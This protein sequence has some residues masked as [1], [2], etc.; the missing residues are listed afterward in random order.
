M[1]RDCTEHPLWFAIDEQSHV[2]GIQYNTMTKTTKVASVGLKPARNNNKQSK[3]SKNANKSKPKQAYVPAWGMCL[4]RPWKFMPAHIPDNNTT[5]SGLCTSRQ[6]I[7]GTVQN[8]D[9]APSTTHSFGLVLPPYPYYTQFTSVGTAGATFGQICD[10]T[11][12]GS[13]YTT[14]SGN[15]TFP[16]AIPNSVA[17]LG[18]TSTLSE[19]SRIRCVGLSVKVIYEGTD[20]QRSGKF[21]AALAPATGLGSVTGT[22]NRISALSAVLG[23]GANTVYFDPSVIFNNVAPDSYYETRVSNEP[24]TARWLP[25]GTP[26]YQ[27]ATSLPDPNFYTSTTAGIDPP[28]TAITYWNAP[29]GGTGLQG[30]QN[31]LIVGVVGDTTGTSTV[32]SNPYTFEV[33]WHWEVIPDQPQSVAYPLSK[34][35]ANSVLLDKCLNGMQQLSV[36]DMSKNGTA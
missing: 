13:A 12:N 10:L 5:L 16:T 4:A 34:S 9:G 7:R 14:F 32:S 6:I 3:R 22:G 1:P 33:I 21:I 25:A 24:F 19:K 11:P 29:A 18:T 15:T 30:G 8:Q 17:V 36:V 20:L 31:V 23:T 26:T 2:C 27:L 28:S 35:D